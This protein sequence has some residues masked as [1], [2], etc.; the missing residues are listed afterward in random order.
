MNKVILI[1]NIGKDPEVKY[2]GSGKAVAKV[3]LATNERYKDEAGEWKEKAEW[4]NIVAWERTAE[5][6]KEYVKKGDKLCVD[7]RIQTRSWDDKQTGQK[8]YMTEIVADRIEL[9]GSP[10][11]T[12]P[13]KKAEAAPD[14]DFPF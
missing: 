13:E 4:H 2:T 10:G 9:L 3:A 5:V 12:K 7:G 8:K 1:G 14:N 6:I 11:G